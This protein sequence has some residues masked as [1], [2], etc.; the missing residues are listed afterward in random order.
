MKKELDIVANKLFTFEFN[1]QKMAK[2]R[3]ETMEH[4]LMREVMLQ[5]FNDYRGG[6][7]SFVD[8]YSQIKDVLQKI[9]QG[10]DKEIWKE[11]SV[12]T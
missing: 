11:T 1:G 6:I 9:I 12:V 3:G 2:Q 4:Y 8:E 10:E 5:Y 7:G